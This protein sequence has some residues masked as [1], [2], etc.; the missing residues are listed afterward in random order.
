[1]SFLARGRPGGERFGGGRVRGCLRLAAAV[2]AARPGRVNLIG[3]HTDYNA[4]TCLPV[5]LPTRRTP[6]CRRART[7]WCGC[8]APRPTTTWAGHGIGPGEVKGW[9]GYV[10]G[11][12]W[13]LRGPAST[14]RGSTCASTAPCRSAPGS[15]RRP[16]WSA[17][18]RSRSPSSLAWPTT[19]PDGAAG[20]RLHARRDRG[21][22]RARPA[23]W[24]RRWRCWPSAGRGAAHRLP[25]PHHDRR[26][27]ATGP[28][29]PGD[30]GHRHPGLPCARRRR[31]REPPGRLRGRRGARGA[32]AARG[33]RSTG[34]EALAD[35]RI[36]RRARHVVTEIDRVRGQ[37][38]PSG[39][40]TGRRWAT[41]SPPR[42]P[43]CATTSR[44]PAPSSTSPSTL[45]SAPV[46]SAPG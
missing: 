3:E 6:P 31:L 28:A 25:R 43:R 4:G 33:H 23:A 17:R 27:P 15:R 12:A 24:T 34:V 38:R 9:A 7:A 10:A 1:M 36:R 26:A 39:R 46:R 37:S 16:R 29:G 42:T 21:R 40:R 2:W 8:A 30:P 32:V 18:S 14:C 41:C 13:A 44:S 45:P 22:R 11:V 20:H 19:R 35:A 5:A